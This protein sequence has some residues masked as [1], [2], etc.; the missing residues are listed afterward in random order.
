MPKAQWI[1]R[2]SRQGSLPQAYMEHTREYA[3]KGRAW[4][5]CLDDFRWE[6]KKLS[7]LCFSRLPF[8]KASL[9]FHQ[10]RSYISPNYIL[11]DIHES[12]TTGRGISTEYKPLLLNM[13]KL[14]NKKAQ[15]QVTSSFCWSVKQKQNPNNT[16]FP[17]N[18]SEYI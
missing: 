5:S 7:S 15:K 4:T 12:S 8:P 9:D 14:K 11:S 2:I 16:L 18:M 13:Q 1:R 6:D 17:Y 3:Q 10:L